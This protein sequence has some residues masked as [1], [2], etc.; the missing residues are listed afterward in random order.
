MKLVP[1]QIAVSLSQPAMTPP[2]GSFALIGLTA[3]FVG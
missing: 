3:A 1:T 2:A